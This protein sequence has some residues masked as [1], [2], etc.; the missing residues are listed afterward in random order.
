[1]TVHYHGLVNADGTHSRIG[2]RFE[3]P[4]DRYRPPRGLRARAGRAIRATT[5]SASR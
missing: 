1:M 4:G 2:D 5:G 3:P